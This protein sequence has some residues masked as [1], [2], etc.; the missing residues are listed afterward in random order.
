MICTEM[1]FNL[2]FA[3]PSSICFLL[4]YLLSTTTRNQKHKKFKKNN[5]IFFLVTKCSSYF[6]F[7]ILMQK[8]SFSHKEEKSHKK[9]NLHRSIKIMFQKWHK[10]QQ[11]TNKQTIG[12]FLRDLEFIIRVFRSEQQTSVNIYSKEESKEKLTIA[13]NLD[14][15]NK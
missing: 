3:L 12:M 10:S 13:I 5:N 4:F 1:E 15:R 8:K 6:I 9:L 7:F 11:R 14:I 2:L